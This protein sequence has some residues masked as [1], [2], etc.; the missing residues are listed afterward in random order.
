[1]F[2]SLMFR[3]SSAQQQ[4]GSGPRSGEDKEVI[5]IYTLLETHAISKIPVVSLRKYPFLYL[6][7]WC[8]QVSRRDAHSL[9]AEDAVAEILGENL[10]SKFLMGESQFCSPLGNLRAVTVFTG[11]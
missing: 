4:N 11:C 10:V 8:V 1:M 9:N 3:R 6:G 2:I 5:F 7:Y